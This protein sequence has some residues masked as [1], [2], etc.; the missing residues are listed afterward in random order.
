[1][2]NPANVVKNRR[3]FLQ[4]LAASPVLAMSAR[5]ALANTAFELQTRPDDPYIWKPFDPNYIVTKPEDAL[6][7]FEL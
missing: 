3:K 6:D 1:M 2:I 4:Y 5:E 7:V